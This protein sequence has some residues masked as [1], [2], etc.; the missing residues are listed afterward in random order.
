MYAILTGF[1]V[2]LSAVL[3]TFVL[4][5]HGRGADAGAAFGSGASATVFGARGSASFLSRGTAIVA[6]LFFANSLILAYL[7]TGQV[8]QGS[9][10][11]SVV[12]TEPPQEPAS[13]E[14]PATDMPVSDTPQVDEQAAVPSDVPATNA[15]GDAAG[16]G[17]PAVDGQKA[18][19]SDIPDVNQNQ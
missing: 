7:S 3:I 9:V 10:L 8:E 1:H 5:Q 15:E 12:T 17:V 13:P 4:L 2:L 16:S 18:P 11:Q 14:V 19:S 6:A